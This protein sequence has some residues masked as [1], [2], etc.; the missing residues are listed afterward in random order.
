MAL[1]AVTPSRGASTRWTLWLNAPV[2]AVSIAVLVAAPWLDHRLVWCEW[3]GVAAA[4]VLVPHIRGWWGEV[5]TLVGAI[6]A[7]TIAF[8]WTPEVLAYAMNTDYEVGLL[9]AAP[10]V[11]WDAVRL[12]LPLWFAARLTRD[13]LEAWLPAGL[14]AAAVEA[15][16]PAIFPWKLGYSQAAWPQLIQSVDVFG[17]EFAT[18]VLFAHAGVIVWLMAALT[19]WLAAGRGVFSRVGLVAVAVCMA[20]VGYG[21]GAMSYWKARIDEAPQ[22]RVALVQ[23]NPEDEGGVDALRRLTQ[24]HC[25]GPNRVPDVVCWPECSG[26]SYDHGLDSLAD[27]ERVVALSREPNRGMRPLD[28]PACPLLF[29]GKIYTGHPEKPQALHQSAILIDAAHA[30]LG[31]YHKRHLMPFGEYVPGADLFPE[32]RLYFPMQD[33]M[34]EGTDAT[35]LACAPGAKLGVMLCYED[36]IPG[37]ARTLV[38]QSAN[39]LISLINGSAFTAPLTLRQHRLLAQLRAVEC[40]R[41]L[42]RCAATGETCV[43]SPLGIVTAALPLNVRDVLPATVPLLEAHSLASR[44]GPLFPLVAAG[45]AV[46]LAL[47][48]RVGRR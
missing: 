27:P 5:W 11:L 9:F 34:T 47:S 22:L 10:I 14:A 31:R 26:G 23:A 3:L 41:S 33:E 36:M 46:A 18:F 43:V 19:G 4:L 17:P 35:V 1:A 37:A 8:H 24:E 38:H 20:N 6:A 42:L 30:I 40:R 48:R 7:L 13:P 25:S 32:M 21:L 12:A 15:I 28:D 39:V 2:A 29:G 45:G 16:V 44:V